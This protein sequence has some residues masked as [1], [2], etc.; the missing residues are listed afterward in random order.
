MSEDCVVTEYTDETNTS[1]A[2]NSDKSFLNNS[3]ISNNISN[4]KCESSENTSNNNNTSNSNNSNKTELEKLIEI[5]KKGVKNKEPGLKY[6]RHPELLISSLESLNNMIG[7]ERIKD[8]AAIQTVRLIEN[9]K[10]GKKNMSMLNTVLSGPAGIGKT[11]TAMKLAKIWWSLGFLEGSENVTVTNTKT[12]TTTPGAY[13]TVDNSSNTGIAL[14]LIL[15]LLGLYCVQ[16]ATYVWDNLTRQLILI[17][18]FVL[19][20]A[21]FIWWYWELNTECVTKYFVK[22]TETTQKVVTASDRDLITVVSRADFIGE[23]MGHTAIKTRRLLEA[24]T[25]RVLFIDEAYS[26]INDVRDSYGREALDVINLYLSENPDKIVVIFA[27]Y[28]EQIK[29][30]IFAAQPGLERRCMWTFNC[31]PYTGEQLYEIFVLQAKADGWC[32]SEMDKPKIKRL[33]TLN[34][35]QFKAYGGDTERLVYLAGLESARSTLSNI[36]DTLLSQVETEDKNKVK[37]LTFND[38]ERALESFKDNRL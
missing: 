36:S 10:N 38:V 35:Y 9:L 23:Y 8:S 26:L 11:Q 1:D 14:M 29:A 37:Y 25:G 22:K 6:I 13:P 15:S 19:I 5:I 24:N 16:I 3:N 30:T 18:G 32:I 12:T 31:N 21:L 34:L 28:Y 7:L 27:G 20:L 17:L 2:N 4:F 33:I